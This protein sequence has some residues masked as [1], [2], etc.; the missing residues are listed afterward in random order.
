MSVYV[1]YY[2]GKCLLVVPGEG[3]GISSAV[4]EEMNLI[5]DAYSIFLWK[6]FGMIKIEFL[7]VCF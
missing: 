3:A 4:E 6:L 2:R 5:W 7:K 1:L